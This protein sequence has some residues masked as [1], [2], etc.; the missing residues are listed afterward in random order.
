MPEVEEPDCG[1][2]PAWSHDDVDFDFRETGFLL[3][4]FDAA[5]GT[6]KDTPILAEWRDELHV[7]KALVQALLRWTDPCSP[8]GMPWRSVTIAIMLVRLCMRRFSGKH[9]HQA[10]VCGAR[11]WRRLG[12]SRDSSADPA[13]HSLSRPSAPVRIGFIQLRLRPQTC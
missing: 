8:S 1:P 6:D 5:R 7:P 13:T 11:Y 3:I 12:V 10:G 2:L 4:L 9:P